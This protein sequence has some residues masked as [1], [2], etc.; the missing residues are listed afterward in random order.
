[1]LEGHRHQPPDRRVAVGPVVVSAHPDAVALQIPDADLEGLVAALGQQPTDLGVAAGSQ[2]RHALGAGE[3]VVERLH[4]L[5]DPLATVLPGLVEPLP[6]QLA[7]IGVQDLAA[8]PL[9]RLGL[10]PEAVKPGET[11]CGYLVCMRASGV[12]WLIQ[13]TVGSFGGVG[14]RANRAGWAA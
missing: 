12:G 1:M 7:R 14:G 9:D 4:A 11:S 8:E 10:D 5:V 6:V 13:A 2:Q 3:A